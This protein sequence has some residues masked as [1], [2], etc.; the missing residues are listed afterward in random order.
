M[1]AVDGDL[2]QVDS[3]ERDTLNGIASFPVVLQLSASLWERSHLETSLEV[4]CQL[5]GLTRTVPVRFKLLGSKEEMQKLGS[6]Y[7]KIN[8]LRGFDMLFLFSADVA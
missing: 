5:T 4:T 1:N 3:P 8:D 2:I 6:C 7:Y